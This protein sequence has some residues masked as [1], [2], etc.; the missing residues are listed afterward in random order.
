[1]SILSKQQLSALRAGGAW[2]SII[3][4]RLSSQLGW[5]LREDLLL[6]SSDLRFFFFNILIYTYV[7]PIV[8]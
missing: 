4:T 5:P 7:N 8:P 1:M 6:Y 3:M 2:K